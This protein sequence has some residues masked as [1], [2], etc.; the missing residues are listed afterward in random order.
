M[1]GVAD[2][3]PS[4][5]VKEEYDF[6]VTHHVAALG[7]IVGDAEPVV[8]EFL[9]GKGHL[10]VPFHSDVVVDVHVVDRLITVC[11]DDVNDGVHQGSPAAVTGVL[12]R[13]SCFLVCEAVGSAVSDA[14]GPLLGVA[15]RIVPEPVVHE[16]DKL[17][18]V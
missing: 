12:E 8:P 18:G 16:C 9:N 5:A 15:G 11:L 17:V 10:V 6:W 2:R 7:V 3:D 4:I 13:L 1:L 14:V